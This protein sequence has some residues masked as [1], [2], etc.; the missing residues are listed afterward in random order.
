[1]DAKQI[2]AKLT[3]AQRRH[4]EN[5]CISGDF[6]MATV[7]VLARKGLFYLRIDSPNGKCGFMELTPLGLE[8]RALLAPTQSGA[9]ND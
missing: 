5:G 7:N 6:A 8:V 3:P 4:I 2:A 9:N 1:M